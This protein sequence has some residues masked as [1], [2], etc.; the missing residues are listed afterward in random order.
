MHSGQ[1]HS[2]AVCRALEPWMAE[3]ADCSISF[4]HVLSKLKWKIH[5]EAHDEC[6]AFNAP[7]VQHPSTSLDSVRQHVT[8]S[9]QGEWKTLFQDP[10]YRGHNFLMLQQ[11]DETILE[12]S[13]ING[14]VSLTTLR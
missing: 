8:K 6:Q 1:G 14:D 13:Y 5:Q 3:D 4:I 2:L 9:I 10:I 12:P 11:P 7:A